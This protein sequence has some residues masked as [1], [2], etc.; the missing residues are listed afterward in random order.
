MQQPTEEP[1]AIDR[2]APEKYP[3]DKNRE[4]REKA[5]QTQ[6]LM[7]FDNLPMSSGQ[8]ERLY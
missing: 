8:G 1:Q 3:N 7:R 6:Y 2:D 5:S 4:T